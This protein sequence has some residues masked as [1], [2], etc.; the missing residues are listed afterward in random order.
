MEQND[1]L[2]QLF[3]EIKELERPLSILKNEEKFYELC[4]LVKINNESI[5]PGDHF[6]ENYAFLKYEKYLSDLYLVTGLN[7]NFEEFKEEL[8]QLKENDI[9]IEDLEEQLAKKNEEYK[10]E[11]KN[12]QKNSVTIYDIE[13]MLT[14]KHKE[15]KYSERNQ[16]NKKGYG[17]IIS[18]LEERGK[19]R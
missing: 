11:L 15:Y 5:I 10:K 12:Q 3:C 6:S 17:K 18:L 9:T 7:I 8:D 1:L 13:N 16:D 19:R 4:R 2:F 14:K